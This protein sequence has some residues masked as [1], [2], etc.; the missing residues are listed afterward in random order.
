MQ[1]TV[2]AGREYLA[3]TYEQVCVSFCLITKQDIYILF[4]APHK[5]GKRECTAL[6]TFKA[7]EAKFSK[8]AAGMAVV[9][10]VCLG[11]IYYAITD[12][13]STAW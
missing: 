6:P 2:Y 8:A 1:F 12:T 3:H 4:F 7:H 13:E 11:D 10:G 9:A 5:P